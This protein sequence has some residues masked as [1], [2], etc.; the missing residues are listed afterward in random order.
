MDTAL[1]QR[2]KIFATIETEQKSRVA[3][4]SPGLRQRSHSSTNRAGLLDPSQFMKVMP[5]RING[6][7]IHEQAQR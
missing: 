1:D 3:E 6:M 2:A 4:H 5:D 7:P